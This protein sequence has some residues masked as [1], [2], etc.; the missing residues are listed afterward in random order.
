MN[1]LL[2]GHK[3]FIGSYMLSALA[4]HN[5]RTFEW[6]G[7]IPDLKGLDW[8]IHMGAITST[9]ERNI[10][11]IFL[12]NYDFSVWLYDECKKHNVGFQFASSASVYGI[13]D[14]F[15]E[16]AELDPRSA[17][18]WS[19]CLFE[20]YIRRNPINRPAQIFRYFTVYGPEGEEHKGNQASPYY[21]FTRQAKETGV[22]KMFEGSEHYA[23]DFIH[24]SEIVETHLAFLNINETDVWNVGT[25]QATSFKKIAETIAVNYGAVIE[26]IPMPE[27]LKMSYQKYTCADMTKM[28]MVRWQSG[29]M[30]E[31]A[32]L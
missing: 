6:G 5:V 8:I 23:R 25:G 24:V 4:G 22:I 13:T 15:K 21:Q 9:T 17:Y 12:Q 32:K 16:T 18:S 2:T 31:S 10:D 20:R 1:I 30:Q 29:P 14:N 11:Q 19:K 28:N 3:G 7:P 27:E 26:T